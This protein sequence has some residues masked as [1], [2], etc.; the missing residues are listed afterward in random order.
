M[1]IGTILPSYIRELKYIHSETYTGIITAVLFI[2][3]KK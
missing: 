2:I 1:T 3:A